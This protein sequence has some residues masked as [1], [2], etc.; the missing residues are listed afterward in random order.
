MQFGVG[1]RTLNEKMQEV[2]HQKCGINLLTS[3]QRETARLIKEQYCEFLSDSES[4]PKSTDLKEIKLPDGKLI[5][6]PVSALSEISEMLFKPMEPTILTK[7][8]CDF[9]GLHQ[10]IMKSLEKCDMDS[11]PDLVRNMILAGGN[12]CFP[13][14][15]NR[16][17]FEVSNLMPVSLKAEVKIEARENRNIASWLGGAIL[18]QLSTAK[19]CMLS[20]KEYEEKGYRGLFSLNL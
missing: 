2:L 18:G 9:Q 5:K 13:N 3:A 11:R 12:T 19:I 4:P 6:I 20:K 7:M 15:E 1:G 16:L 8:S 17:K 14:L 10:L